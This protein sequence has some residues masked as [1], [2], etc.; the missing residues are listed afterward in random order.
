[1]FPFSGKSITVDLCSV[2]T[3]IRTSGFLLTGPFTISSSTFTSMVSLYNCVTRY[4][5]K[6]VQGYW[7]G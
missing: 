7:N 5:S 6:S 3:K 2:V 1:M 4:T